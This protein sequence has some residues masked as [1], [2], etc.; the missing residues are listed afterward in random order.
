[1]AHAIS[2]AGTGLQSFLW[3]SSY[4]LVQA[5]YPEVKRCGQQHSSLFDLAPDVVYHAI[6]VTSNPVSSYLAFSPLPSTQLRVYTQRLSFQNKQ[7][8]ARRYIFCGTG[9]PDT[10]LKIDCP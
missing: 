7:L 6:A 2:G 1:M 4:L 8:S 3:T 9:R 5:I 10:H